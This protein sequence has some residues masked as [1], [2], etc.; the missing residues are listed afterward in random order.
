MPDPVR[1]ANYLR[2]DEL[3]TAFNLE[4]LCS[5]WDAARLR[6]VIDSTL[7]Y[8]APVGAPAT[9]LLSNHDVTRVVTRYGRED[10]SFSFAAK[11][12]DTPTDLE[13]GTRRARA[14]ALLTLALPGSA[15]V[16]QGEELGLWEVEDIPPELRQDPMW[17]RSG[18]TD[19]G[20]DGCRVPLPW[21]GD[22]PPFGF[23]PLG[24][25][26]P[27]LPQP[28]AWKAYT[29]QAQTGDPQSMLELY[30]SALRVRRSFRDEPFAWM[31]S[32]PEVLTFQRGEYVCVVNLSDRDVPLP[33]HESIVLASGPVDGLVLAPDTAVYLIRRSI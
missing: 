4:F 2:P 10:T 6:N 14:A 27:W 7:A 31:A 9:W 21:S 30:R 20:R 17:H 15:Y 16:Y 12:H 18:R 28:G 22:E 11:R 29:V 19:P 8:H 13:L 33:A 1:F 26:M 5:P 3:H 32:G 25:A 23:S 24:S